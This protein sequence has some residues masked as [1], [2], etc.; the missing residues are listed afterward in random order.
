M[1]PNLINFAIPFFFILIFAEIII[2]RVR[3]LKIYRLSD[4]ISDL[5]SGIVSQIV[6]V[7]IK[8]LGLMGYAYIYEKARLF[9]WDP[10]SWLTWTIAL[11]GQDFFYYWAHRLSHEVN[12]LW[13]AHVVHHQ[14]E[15]YNLT[16]ALRQSA[17]QG[18]FTQ[19]VYFPLAILGI[20]PLHFLVAG[21][22]SLIYQFW[23]H[24]QVIGKM[25]FLEYFLNTP[26]HHRVHHAINPQY[27]DKNHGG[28]LIIWDKLF[29]TFAPEEESCVYGTV[30]PLKS[31]NVLWANFHYYKDIWELA[32]KADRLIDKIKVWFAMPG[33][34]PASKGTEAYQKEVPKVTPESFVKYNPIMSKSLTIY[35]VFWFVFLALITFAF[36]LFWQKLLSWQMWAL[37]FYIIFSLLSLGGITE[38]KNWSLFTEALRFVILMI[39]GWVYFM[40]FSSILVHLVNVLSLISLLFLTHHRPEREVIVEG[41]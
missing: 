15:E 20:P 9:S 23:I 38:G 36:L 3:K 29:G 5:S 24:T 11:I 2:G 19:F 7:F 6:G 31:Y 32:K 21:Q 30:K 10:S 40:G 14:S 18:L 26:S 4:S 34:V 1:E 22:I 25:G 12:L 28:T 8:F 39:I 13:A 17:F 37:G 16:V 27:I 33:W 41:G 35:V